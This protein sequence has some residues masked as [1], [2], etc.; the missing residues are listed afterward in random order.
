MV[1]TFDAGLKLLLLVTSAQSYQSLARRISCAMKDSE[2]AQP[3]RARI[4]WMYC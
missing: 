1:L 4:R 2:S 3:K